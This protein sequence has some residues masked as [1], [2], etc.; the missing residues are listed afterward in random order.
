MV[1][2]E[3]TAMITGHES[4]SGCAEYAHQNAKPAA[5]GATEKKGIGGGAFIYVETMPAWGQRLLEESRPA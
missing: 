4:E 1:A 2:A 5:L 3:T